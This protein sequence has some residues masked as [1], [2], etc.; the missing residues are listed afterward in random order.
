[1]LVEEEG[2]S[3]VVWVE[4]SW[5]GYLIGP[6][7]NILVKIRNE[8]IQVGPDSTRNLKVILSKAIS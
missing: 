6:M 2:G 7:K 5:A 1:M 3:D 4:F 8:A